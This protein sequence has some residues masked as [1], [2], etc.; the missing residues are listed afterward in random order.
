MDK[1]YNMTTRNGHSFYE[2]SSMLQKAIRRGLYEDAFYAANELVPQYRNYMWKRLFIVSAEDCHDLVSAHVYEL[3]CKD[4]YVRDAND[5]Q[6][7][8]EAVGYLVGARK[9]RDADYF[10]CNLMNSRDRKEI[11]PS[12]EPTLTE[13]TEVQYPTK[14]GHGMFDVSSA[15]VNA[16]NQADYELVGY[17]AN[18]LY[19]RYKNFL[20]KTIMM[21]AKDVCNGHPAAM[22]EIDSLRR[23]DKEQAGAVNETPIYVAKALVVLVKLV[24]YD[25]S[26]FDCR[27]E[28]KIADM[29]YYDG[30][31]IAVPNYVFDCHTIR[32]KKMGKTKQMFVVDEQKALNPLCECEFDHSSWD[33][34][35]EL[36]KIGF[37]DKDNVTPRPSEKTMKAISKGDMQLNLFQTD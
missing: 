12:I 13:A 28:Y 8:S 21:I 29:S 35:F 5:R 18:E 30:R 24:K 33:R 7:I 1:K 3:K 6:Y 2:I 34:F 37:Y 4:A 32:G 22:R 11:C 31:Y 26:I 16:V 14:N 19:V 20:W 25:A 27:Y 17:T 23:I 36:N 10:A 9:N 15:L